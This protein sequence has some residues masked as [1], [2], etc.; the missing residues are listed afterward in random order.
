VS[1]KRDALTG[2]LKEFASQR[3]FT[4]EITPVGIASTPLLEGQPM[5]REQFERLPAERQAQ[6]KQ[7]TTVIEGQ[8]AA[9]L[10]RMHA[11]EKETA[12]RIKELER[13]VTRFATGRL[14]HELREK[15]AAQAEILA[16]LEQME[17]DVLDNFDDFREGDEGSALPA[18]LGGRHRGG[19]DRYRV[20]VLVDNGG[21]RGAPVVEER[22]PT[23]YNLLGRV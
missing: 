2:E 13:E 16:Y 22:N 9:F 3:G 14:F 19:L 18:F 21:A 5:K 15:Y 12:D 20:N 8:T 7:A 23:Y 6:V 4:L 17:E 1:R 10:R 11:L